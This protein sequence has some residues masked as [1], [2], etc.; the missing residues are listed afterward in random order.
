M[1]GCAVKKGVWVN[2]WED[3][4]VR[5]SDGREVFE[6]V[7]HAGMWPTV[8]G[9]CSAHPTLQPLPRPHIEALL[10]LSPAAAR[11]P[12]DALRGLEGLG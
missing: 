11:R 10:R 4:G 12:Y 8:F 5:K 3:A 9:C 1:D 2:W 6:K 7:P